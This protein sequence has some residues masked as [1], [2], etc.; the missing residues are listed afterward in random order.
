MGKPP[1]SVGEDDKKYF[2]CLPP[3]GSHYSCDY[4][5]SN[6]VIAPSMTTRR[7][8]NACWHTMTWWRM[9]ISWWVIIW[10]VS[11]HP[12]RRP[13][14][15]IRVIHW[16]KLISAR[17]PMKNH[18]ELRFP[19]LKHQFGSLPRTRAYERNMGNNLK[20]TKQMV[21]QIDQVNKLLTRMKCQRQSDHP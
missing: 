4:N 8:F 7:N 15:L 16:Q 13:C 1:I 6:K 14:Q 11:S 10:V 5:V 20:K 9:K 17:P 19:S 21:P 2:F 3:I 12:Y 18:M